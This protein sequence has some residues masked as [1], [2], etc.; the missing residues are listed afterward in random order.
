MKKIALL[1]ICFLAPPLCA[2]LRIEGEAKVKPY[3]IVRLEAKGQDEKAGILWRVNPSRDID[4]ALS[5]KS[6]L[7]FVAPPGTYQVECLALRIAPDGSTTIESVDTTVTIS[8]TPEIK[9]IPL[10]KAD[11][12]GATCRLRFGSSGCTATVIGPRRND[13]RWDILT[14]SH[15]TPE[16][17]SSGEIT[18]KDGRRFKVTV[19]ARE[20]GP[21]LA[22]LRTEAS[23][24]EMPWATL[25]KDLPANGT[26]VW[27]MAYGID[28][29]GNKEE[30]AVTSQP[31]K[32]GL[33]SFRLSVS[34]G[35]SG[36]GIF[37]E[38]TGELVS[39]VCCT[40]ERGKLT[41]MY[42]GSCIEA[43]RMRPKETKEFDPVETPAKM[44]DP[45]KE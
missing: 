30:G 4:K 40:T 21:D 15:C 29:A 42:G 14:A 18:L 16:V 10:P 44:P 45:P 37:R 36:G 3:K 22:W 43:Q 12:I 2:Q 9:P 39:A 24:E 35:D 13:G 20:R 23:P 5:H 1:L 34:S 8:A 17:G 26:K 32:T 31:N 19:I 33:L 38:D 7:H 28:K 11:P 27:H 6:Q 41:T 25:A